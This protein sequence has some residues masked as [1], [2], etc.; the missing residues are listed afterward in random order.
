MKW[1]IFKNNQNKKHPL[2]GHK[3]AT[4]QHNSKTI[5]FGLAHALHT[6]EFIA[7]I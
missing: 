4:E 7:N 1:W 6:F 2:R 5:W 3:Q